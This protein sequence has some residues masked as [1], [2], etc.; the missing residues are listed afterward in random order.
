M[1]AKTILGRRQQQSQGAPEV[2]NRLSG[3]LT[4]GN[5]LHWEIGLGA[6]FLLGYLAGI[7]LGREQTPAFGAALAQYHLDKQNYLS[8]AAVFASSFSALFVQAGLIL[9]CGTNALGALLLAVFFV[10]KGMLLGIE[11]VAVLQLADARGL[12]VYWLLTALPNA[13]ALILLLWLAVNAA[14][15]AASL[16]RTVLNGT[17]THGALGRSIRTLMLRYIIT[18]CIGAACL[19][20]GAAAAKLF[21]EILL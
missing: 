1:R 19:A 10:C 12:V 6:L 14:T 17:G 5:R 15:L 3:W 16:F 4:A 7:L 9:L 2:W 21:A 13:V 20:F 11:A 18:L 8:F